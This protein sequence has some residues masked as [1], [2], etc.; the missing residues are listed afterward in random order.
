MPEPLKPEDVNSKTDPSVSKQ[1]DDT[2]P[3]KQQIEEFYKIVDSMKVG[4]LTTIRDG[5]GPVSRSMVVAK[6][7]GPDFLFLANAHSNKFGDLKND[8]QAQI[9]FQN[10]SSQDWVSI[11]GVATT[12][13]NSD[14]R[15]KE[16]YSKGTA[17]WFGDLGD[18]VHNATADDPRMSLIEVQPKYIAYWKTTVGTLGFVKEVAQASFTG[19][20]ATTGVQRQLLEEDIQGMRKEVGGS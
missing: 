9:T 13:S 19:Q 20:V 4:L 12:T 14:P 10:S 6:R 17:A 1:W 8:K 18:G 3:K 2:T 5:I 16:L 15:I 7:V 11:T